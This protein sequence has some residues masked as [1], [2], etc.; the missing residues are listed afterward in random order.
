[1]KKP[2]RSRLIP[3]IRKTDYLFEPN[4]YF[5]SK[6]SSAE[7]G[8]NIGTLGKNLT[9]TFLSLNRSALSARLLA[10]IVKHIP[11]FAGEILIVDNGSAAKEL[12]QLQEACKSFPFRWRI[13]ELEKNHGVGGGRNRTIPYVNTDWIM[14][15]DNDIYFIDDPLQ[16]IQT[17]IALLGCHFLNL[18]L[19]DKDGTVT[20][21]GGHFYI[22]PQDDKYH[23]ICKSAWIPQQQNSFSG[24][25]FLSTFLSGGACVIKKQTFQQIGAYDEGMFIGYEDLDLSIRLFQAGYKIGNTGCFAWVH[26]HCEAVAELDRQY[27][28][29]R[30][31]LETIRGAAEYF[32]KKHKLVVW[33]DALI[34]WIA[35]KE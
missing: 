1:M 30:W 35:A 27:E 11:R 3:G 28:K 24:Q 22:W 19:L 34:A 15:L 7:D 9:I 26:D 21:I 13:V 32:E 10:S 17:D 4:H 20:A 25:C 16:A 6:D 5:L 12:I 33:D 23:T 14:F 29:L 31:S 2:R 8:P 18:P